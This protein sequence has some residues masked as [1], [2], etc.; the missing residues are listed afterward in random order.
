M[1]HYYCTTRPQQ[2]MHSLRTPATDANKTEY[3]PTAIKQG[4]VTLIHDIGATTTQL[5]NFI[6]ENNLTHYINTTPR[7]LLNL[8]IT[9]KRALAKGEVHALTYDGLEPYTDSDDSIPVSRN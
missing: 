1:R 3:L 7:S 9:V 6:I 4:L 2:W 8:R 5:R